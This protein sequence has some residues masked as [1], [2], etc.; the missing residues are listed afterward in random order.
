MLERTML[1]QDLTAEEIDAYSV[2]T[3]ASEAIEAAATLLETVVGAWVVSGTA[4]EED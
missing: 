2:T 3:Q 1:V 4:T